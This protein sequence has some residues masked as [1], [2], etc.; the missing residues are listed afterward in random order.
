MIYT[1]PIAAL[2][3]CL[4]ASS[5]LT[6]EDDVALGARGS[7]PARRVIRSKPTAT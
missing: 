1:R 6:A 4:S 2:L 3:F 5:G 7:A